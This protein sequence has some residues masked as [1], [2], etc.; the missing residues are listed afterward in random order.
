MNRKITILSQK[1]GV[2]KTSVALNLAYAL[3]RIGTQKVLIVDIDP[4][5]GI[6]MAL[7]TK[8]A[9]GVVQILRGESELKDAVVG[10]KNDSVF[11][12]GNGIQTPEDILYMEDEARSGNLRS[13]STVCKDY[14]FVLFDC[15]PG[16]G[17]INQEILAG[18][19]SFIHVIDCRAG[20]VKSMARLLN[21]SIWIKRQINPEL[22]LEGILVNRYQSDNS[23]HGQILQKIKSRIPS[24]FFFKAMLEEDKIF[25]YAAIKGLPIEKF[26][27]GKKT[28]K[29]FLALAIEICAKKMHIEEDITLLAE[30]GLDD[31]VLDLEKVADNEDEP[32]LHKKKPPGD[33]ITEIIR[34]LCNNGRCAGA[35]VADEMG[36]PLAEHQCPFGVDSLSSYGSVL[37]EALADADSILNVEEANNIVMDI[38]EDEKL[39]L[40]RFQLLGSKYYL[41]AV[42]L[43][44]I[45]VL[46]ELRYAAERIAAE[47]T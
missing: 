45:D 36:L 19:N 27:D 43:R 15:P 4:Q 20:S 40:H 41:L 8:P 30:E 32:A 39:V 31:S 42:C 26:V 17:V 34:D 10:L 5:D 7:N 33:R 44:E 29:V 6:G 46:G 37:G 28:A 12:L 22:V 25:E 47:L 3:S 23:I 18:S 35:V 13:F 24:R 1:G 38:N 11:L 16:I 2:G 21:L 14:N 9:A